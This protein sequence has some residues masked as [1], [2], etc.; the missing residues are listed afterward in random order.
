M[1]FVRRSV[2]TLVTTLAVVALGAGAASAAENGGGTGGSVL[3][4]EW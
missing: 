3:I 2:F 4:T 1:R